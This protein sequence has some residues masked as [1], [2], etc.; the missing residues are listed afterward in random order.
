MTGMVSIEREGHAD[1]VLRGWVERAAAF[2]RGLPPK[3][4]K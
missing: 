3:Q 2:V 1:A 4:P